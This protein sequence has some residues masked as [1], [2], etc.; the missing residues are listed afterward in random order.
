MVRREPVSAA[1][2]AIVNRVA[3]GG[4][5][6]KLAPDALADLERRGL[7][8]EIVFTEAPKHATELAMRAAANGCRRFLSVGGD[9]TASEIVNGLVGAGVSEECELAMLPL[10]TG[11][12]F[13]RDFGIMGIE[14][15]ANA[16]ARGESSPIDVLRLTHED[17]VL[18]FIN[19]MGTGFIARAGELTNE[20]FKFLGATGYVAAVLV[21]V[22][23]LQ[24]ERNTLRYGGSVDDARTVLTS[25]SNSQYTGGSMRMAPDARVADGLVDVVRAGPLGRAALV[26]AFARI[27]SGTHTDLEEVRTQQ[28]A[29]VEFVDPSF[30][31]VLID[32][33]LHHLT[34]LSIDVLPGALRLIA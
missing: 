32:G 18:H 19:T 5:C 6:A 14:V 23:R 34:P 7:S 28:V 25:F 15:A 16:I 1:Y 30:Q 13:L 4:R 11:N 22:I 17:G 33:D 12:S 21:C 2:F 9:G 26:A 24:Y 29:H 10:G 20:R 3:G 27:F 8:L 31:A